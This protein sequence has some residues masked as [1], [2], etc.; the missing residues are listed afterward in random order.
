MIYSLTDL[1]NM[2]IPII[3]SYKA[4]H[5]ILFGSYARGE[6]T[7][8]SDIDLMIIGGTAFDPTDI[9]AIAEDLHQL[10]GKAEDLH[11]LSGKNVDVYEINEIDKASPLYESIVKDGIRLV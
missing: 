4:E 8:T 5:A 7:V 11:Q 6:A 9:F 1:R 3:K 10:S 2:I